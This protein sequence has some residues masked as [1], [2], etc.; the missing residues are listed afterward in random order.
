MRQQPNETVRVHGETPLVDSVEGRSMRECLPCSSTEGIAAWAFVG[1]H[2]TGLAHCPPC[3]W[4]ERPARRPERVGAAFSDDSGVSGF[5][6]VGQPAGEQ[7]Q[8][9]AGRTVLA[10]FEVAAGI[11]QAVPR[12]GA[13]RSG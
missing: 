2:G 10:C 8:L 11:L 13:F 7:A 1:D 3:F 12:S 5:L 9:V 6:V 4:T